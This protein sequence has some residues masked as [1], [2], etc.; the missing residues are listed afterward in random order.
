MITKKPPLSFP[1]LPGVY[2]FKDREN[3]VIYIGKAKSLKKRIASYFINQ[4]N[5]WKVSELIKNYES[6]DYIVT[7]TEFEALLLEAQ[8][9]G[10]YKPKYNVLLKYNNPFVY[11]LFDCNEPY[12]I[13][14]VRHKTKK[15]GLVFFGPFVQKND[16]RQLYYYLLK[17]FKLR[18][19]KRSIEQ[20]CLEYHIGN[21]AGSCR[22]DYNHADYKTRL[23][24]AKLLLEGDKKKFIASLE[25]KINE[26]IG[27]FEFEKARNLYTYSQN[28]EAI[29]ATLTA[30][31]TQEKYDSALLAALV[32]PENK[33]K[34]T[35]S[36]GKAIQSFLKLEKTPQTIDCFDISHFQSSAIVGSCIRFTQGSPDKNYFRRFKIRSLVQQNDYAALQEI[37]LRRYKRGDYPDLILIDGGKGQLSAA[38]KVLPQSVCCI[39]LAKKEELIF[40]PNMAEGIPLDIKTEEG[41]T[42]IA[43]RDYAHHFAVAYHKRVRA[44]KFIP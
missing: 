5:D 21:C 35:G 44:K 15:A 13:A 6:I 19:C 25:Q 39:S 20:G 30:K 2:L 28:A 18:K 36:V 11:I 10:Q 4:N 1:D 7:K 38:L 24:C 43:L 26:Y 9:I 14:L 32:A 8:L 41:K 31:Y 27:N 22:S 42:L 12:D 37:V 40:L 33:I 23:L 17:T 16:A 29:F 34:D 3:T